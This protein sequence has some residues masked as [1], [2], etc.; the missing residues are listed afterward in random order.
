[1]L[2][3]TPHAL[4]IQP[5]MRERIVFLH[6]KASG[7]T[8]QVV[9]ISVGFRIETCPAWLRQRICVLHCFLLLLLYNCFWL[10]P[11]Q[12]SRRHSKDLVCFCSC[13]VWMSGF[14]RR[15]LLRRAP[16]QARF[17]AKLLG[18]DVWPI[19]AAETLQCLAL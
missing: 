15:A 13:E 19:S 8:F 2:S 16:L 1:M 18:T 6:H 5:L 12:S 4:P 9:C 14:A 3:W 11:G 10:A 17:S 7:G